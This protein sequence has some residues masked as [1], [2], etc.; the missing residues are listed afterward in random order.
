MD[1]IFWCRSWPERRR[2]RNNY[3]L[4]R[5][6][7][8]H[9]QGLCKRD[10]IASTTSGKGLSALYWC[11]FTCTLGSS[12]LS[13]MSV[14]TQQDCAAADLVVFIACR[15]PARSIE[16]YKCIACDFIS[17]GRINTCYW[18]EVNKILSACSQCNIYIYNGE[19]LSGSSC[20]VL[21]W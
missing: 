7:A 2:S 12:G 4:I 6:E 3:S 11:S 5:K 18:Y 1:F 16:Y 13:Q 20:I 17:M 19:A 14:Y 9:R 15:A 21:I 10:E 8:I